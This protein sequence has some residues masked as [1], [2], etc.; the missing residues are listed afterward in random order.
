M[1]HGN[2]DLIQ[3]EGEQ[4]LIYFG[5]TDGPDMIEGIGLIGAIEEFGRLVGATVKG[6][7]LMEGEINTAEA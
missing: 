4:H 3:A 7:V 1:I 2:V 6:L 5:G